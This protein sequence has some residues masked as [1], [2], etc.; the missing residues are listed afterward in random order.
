[1]R[2]Y[3]GSAKRFSEFMS[4]GCSAE[5]AMSRFLPRSGGL[6]T[7]VGDGRFG[8]RPSL[9]A[10]PAASPLAVPEKIAIIGGGAAGVFAAIACAPA[11]SANEGSLYQRG[12]EFLTKVRISGGRRWNVTHACLAP[13]AIS[14]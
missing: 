10:N 7:A 9:I 8:K 13:R 12:S 11:N 4:A 2:Q 3:A 6:Q 14:E 5:A 1:M